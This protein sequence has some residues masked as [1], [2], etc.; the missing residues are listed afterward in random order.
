MP[1]SGRALGPVPPSSLCCHRSTG[2]AGRPRHS[3]A[4]T[5]TGVAACEW[6]LAAQGH[7]RQTPYMEEIRLQKGSSKRNHTFLIEGKSQ[8][9]AE[10]RKVIKILTYLFGND[11]S[12]SCIQRP[13]C[14]RSS[15]PP[16]SWHTDTERKGI[17]SMD[18]VSI[19]V[20]LL[21]ILSSCLSPHLRTQQMQHTGK[22]MQSS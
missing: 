1:T 2:A 20:F 19:P 9:E 6:P 21:R 3:P 13:K 4:Q 17:L 15:P 8:A 14:L 12:R 22:Q 10:I 11:F 7:A 16:K 18:S 5:G